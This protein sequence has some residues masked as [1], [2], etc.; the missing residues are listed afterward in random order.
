MYGHASSTARQDF[1]EHSKTAIAQRP[2]KLHAAAAPQQPTPA[3]L[4]DRTE[5]EP[6]LH[7]HRPFLLKNVVS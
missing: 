6:S 5:P 4:P 2:V 7:G 3:P 1:Y